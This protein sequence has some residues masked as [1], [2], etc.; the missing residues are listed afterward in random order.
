MSHAL[1]TLAIETSGPAGSVA[2]G[3]SA[4]PLVTRA[5][6]THT[7][8]ASDLLPAIDALLRANDLCAADLRLVCFSAGP[9]SFTGLRLAATAARM[10]L[11]VTTCAVVRVP[12]LD[13]LAQNA[14]AVADPPPRVVAL[15]DAKRDQVFAATFE[16]RSRCGDPD[17]DAG[18]AIYE[19][20]APAGLHDPAAFL[21]RVTTPFAILGA[22]IE[23]HRDVCRASGGETLG[24]EFAVPDAAT[25]YRLG[26][27]AHAIGR[28]AA[29][30]EV[31]PI[32]VRPPEAEEVYESRRA[33][34][35]ARRGE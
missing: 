8:H 35:R 25:V 24:P 32:Y 34:A 29:S 22:G 31:V 9:G 3:D 10:L 21:V 13:V 20:A 18:D 1:W 12:T 16:L 33:A 11:S 14:L 19:A 2:L 23:K 30:H 28:V 5:L 7:R 17:A 15:L 26:R 4:A 6:D 27:T